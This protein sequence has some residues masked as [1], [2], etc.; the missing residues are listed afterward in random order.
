[1]INYYIYNQK[2]YLQ[3]IRNKADFFNESK[4]ER[5]RESGGRGEA[6]RV[7]YQQ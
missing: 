7:P 4:R 5:R 6:D 2:K 1:M 3:T